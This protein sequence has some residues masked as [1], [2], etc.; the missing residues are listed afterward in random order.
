MSSHLPKSTQQVGFNKN[1]NSEAHQRLHQTP[2]HGTPAD[3]A[4]PLC[5]SLG[6][7]ALAPPESVG[8]PSPVGTS[9]PEHTDLLHSVLLHTTLDGLSA[10][11]ASLLPHI[12]I[13]SE[14]SRS[15]LC[16]GSF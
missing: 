11:R 15:Q 10:W 6:I 4:K 3:G 7:L 13:R 16:S 5:K 12:S 14:T 8:R 1:L 9:Q 2:G